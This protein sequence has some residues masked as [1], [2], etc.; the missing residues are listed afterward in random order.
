MDIREHPN[1]KKIDDIE[2]NKK[3]YCKNCHEDWG[4]TALIHNV[5]WLCIKISSFVL[6]FPHNNRARKIFK[7]WKDLPFDIK[8]ATT[9]EI[10]EHGLEPAEN[11][12]LDFDF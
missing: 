5:E 9:E 11:D 7:K 6:E 4:V 8:E 12:L 3:I 2:M 10:L 1:P